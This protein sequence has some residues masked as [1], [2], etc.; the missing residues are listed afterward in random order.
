M[1]GP[2]FPEPNDEEYDPDPDEDTIFDEPEFEDVDA[3]DDEN[4][5]GPLGW[6]P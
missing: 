2:K 5:E 4:D 3:I 1:S 6:I